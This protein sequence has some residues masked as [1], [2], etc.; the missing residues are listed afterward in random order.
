MSGKCSPKHGI[1]ER[2]YGNL[3]MEIKTG[4]PI[5]FLGS[6]YV[7]ENQ[8]FDRF[9]KAIRSLFSVDLHAPRSTGRPRCLSGNDGKVMCENSYVRKPKLNSL[10]NSELLGAIFHD[11]GLWFQM[12]VWTTYWLQAHRNGVPLRASVDSG[13]TCS[14]VSKR[15]VGE[16]SIEKTNHVTM[17]VGNGKTIFSEWTGIFTL[18][19]QGKNFHQKP[20]VVETD[21]FQAI[22]GTESLANLRIRGIVTQPPAC[23]LLVD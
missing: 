2:K 18:N 16:R 14:S 6:R 23:R 21:A 22:L 12:N 20:L 15:F 10:T 8:W 11:A 9:R 5:K 3:Q 1:R 17:Q 13:A 19:L 7:W 4:S